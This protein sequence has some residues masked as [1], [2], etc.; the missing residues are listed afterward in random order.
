MKSKI[1]Y[2]IIFIS[3]CTTV[4]V[5][6]KFPSAPVELLEPAEDL[7]KLETP[8]PE[9][10]DILDNVNTNYGKYFILKQRYQSWQNWYQQQK[11]IYDSID[12][13]K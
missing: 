7:S 9:L 3:G 12:K 2:L 6:Y 5:T 11:S 10:S 4:P 8:D 13:E 1:L